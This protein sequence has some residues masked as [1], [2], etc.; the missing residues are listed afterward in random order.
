MNH[1][2]RPG[3]NNKWGF[4]GILSTWASL[5]CVI[6]AA[7]AAGAAGGAAGEKTPSSELAMAGMTAAATANL[8]RLQAASDVAAAVQQWGSAE[9]KQKWAKEI[10]PV[11][12]PAERIE[13][14][15]FFSS[16][17]VLVGGMNGA[18]SVVAFYN[19]W[20]DGLFL[21][22]M[23]SNAKAPVLTDFSVVSGE[24]F[25]GDTVNPEAS[26][27]LYQLKEPLIIAVA[28]LYSR[29]V[30]LFTSLYPPMGAP[31]LLP[32]T[33]K[34][35]IEPQDAE[36]IPIKTRMMLRM[37]M[38]QTYFAAPNRP[39]VVECGAL[40]KALKDDDAARLLACLAT[41]QDAAVVE[42][43]RMLPASVRADLGPNYFARATDGMVVGFVNPAAPRWLIAATFKGTV[44]AK[45]AARLDLLDLELSGT[46]I[47]LWS[48]ED[49]K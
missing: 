49:K 8:F 6:C 31:V 48:Q 7:P 47:T 25:R 15:D 41:D 2:N 9:F 46:A 38:F 33:V 18:R 19:P 28:R 29:T 14:H 35:R 45:R 16:A 32:A 30:P 10:D 5:T 24:S 23:S 17:V 20:L 3:N 27:A 42:T 26:L 12:S 39:W 43:I 1:K 40:M 11:F 21:A 44:P 36:L 22:A 37:K 4:M 13:W 34:A